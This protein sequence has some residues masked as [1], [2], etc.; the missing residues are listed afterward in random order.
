MVD[1]HHH[2]AQR[3]MFACRELPSLVECLEERTPVEAPGERIPRGQHL[4]LF[5]LLANLVRDFFNSSSMSSNSDFLF[6]IAVTSSKL[7]SMPRRAPRSSRIGAELTL[8]MRYL[9]LAEGSE[10]LI[11]ARGLSLLN[12]SLQGID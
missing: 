9:P 11:P 8:K 4:E 12:N 2:A 6:S 5:V 1:I 3:L 7:A 10:T